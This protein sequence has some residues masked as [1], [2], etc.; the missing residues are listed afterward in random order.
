MLQAAAGDAI[1]INAT[2]VSPT[3]ALSTTTPALN[4]YSK[5]LG[6]GVNDVLFAGTDGSVVQLRF[7]E[8]STQTGAQCFIYGTRVGG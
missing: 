1:T 8:S 6:S 5:D 2:A 3:P 7:Q 4:D